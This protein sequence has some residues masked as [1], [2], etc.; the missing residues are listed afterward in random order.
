MV[1]TSNILSIQYLAIMAVWLNDC[2]LTFQL[3]ESLRHCEITQ[4]GLISIDNIIIKRTNNSTR[5]KWKAGC[6]SLKLPSCLMMAARVL[7]VT[8]S[9]SLGTPLGRA[10]RQRCLGSMLLFTSGMT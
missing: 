7:L 2:S 1:F 4:I 3:G 5:K 9:S 10:P 8:H 6:H